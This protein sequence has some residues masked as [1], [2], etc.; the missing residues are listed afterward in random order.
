MPRLW[1]LAVLAEQKKFWLLREG[2]NR[3]CDE[4]IS[5]DIVSYT[6]PTS[7]KPQSW[8]Q[9]RIQGSVVLDTLLSLSQIFAGF[10]GGIYVEVR[11]E[12]EN[13]Q[14][15]RYSI[16]G[17][18]IDWQW[19][20]LAKSA[21]CLTFSQTNIRSRSMSVQDDLGAK[22]L[23]ELSKSIH[24]LQFTN[25]IFLSPGTARRLYRTVDILSANYNGQLFPSGNAWLPWPSA[26]IRWLQTYAHNIIHLFSRS[27][28][29]SL[30]EP[31]HH[32]SRDVSLNM[33]IFNSCMLYIFLRWHPQFI[34]LADGHSYGA[35]I[36]SDC[37]HRLG[38]RIP[39][40]GNDIAVWTSRV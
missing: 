30:L 23:N 28:R 24:T 40:T 1:L 9:I 6:I 7:I 18:N 10:A 35:E 15:K 29:W 3:S 22:F 5:R 4:C 2:N 13:R 33:R 32:L 14:F 12:N 8:V 34:D 11:W 38:N 37:H 39:F 17:A 25:V 36:S 27:R 16:S 21:R 31:R 20:V 26:E 19:T